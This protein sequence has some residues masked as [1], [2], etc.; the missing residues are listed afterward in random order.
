MTLRSSDTVLI[1]HIR[2]IVLMKIIMLNRRIQAN[3]LYQASSTGTSKNAHIPTSKALKANAKKFSELL[4]TSNKSIKKLY[5]ISDHVAYQNIKSAFFLLSD[6]RYLDY[7]IEKIK[8][9]LK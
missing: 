7:S 3:A 1:Q 8:N 2:H 4:S 5:Y 6:N 9:I